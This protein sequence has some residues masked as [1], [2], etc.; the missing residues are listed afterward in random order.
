MLHKTLCSRIVNT[1]TLSLSS[2]EKLYQDLATLVDGQQEQIDKLG[3]HAEETKANTKAG[4]E[5]FQYRMWKMCGEQQEQDTK[6]GMVDP[7]MPTTPPTS[8]STSSVR[9]Y[10]KACHGAVGGILPSVDSSLDNPNYCSFMVKDPNHVDTMYESSKNDHNRHCYSDLHDMESE[11]QKHPCHNMSSTNN[12]D[13]TMFEWMRRLPPTFENLRSDVKESAHGAYQ[14]G[15]ALVED[16]VEQVMW[17]ARSN[18]TARRL[19]CTPMADDFSFDDA[20][21]RSMEDDDDFYRNGYRDE[22]KV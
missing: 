4:L 5:Q 9:H 6:P 21:D 2:F 20:N 10:C 15:H 17:A 19:T 12:D 11:G 3:E 18:Q 1:L 13:G 22:M 7:R 8:C 16:L 14:V